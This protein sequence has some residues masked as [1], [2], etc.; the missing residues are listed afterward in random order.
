MGYWLC[1][2]DPQAATKQVGRNTSQPLNTNFSHDI[3][4]AYHC[5]KKPEN[6]DEYLV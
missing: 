3:N 6:D 4:L 5:T 1:C 2:H